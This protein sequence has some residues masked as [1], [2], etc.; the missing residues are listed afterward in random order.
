MTDRDVL[1]TDVLH[2]LMD[3]ASVLDGDWPG[4]AAW[5]ASVGR[6]IRTMSDGRW[7]HG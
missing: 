5:Q 6:P 3:T 7:R 4:L 1:D 2:S